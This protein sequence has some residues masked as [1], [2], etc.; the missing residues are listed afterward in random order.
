MKDSFIEIYKRLSE[1]KEQGIEAVLATV[2]EKEGSTPAVP[3]AKLLITTD[4]MKSGTVGG[5]ALE[6]AV[7]KDAQ[8]VMHDGKSML[9]KYNLSDDGKIVDAEATGMI[10]GGKVAIFFEYIAPANRIY[11]FGAGHVGK[12]ILY[13]LKNSD[14]HITVIDNRPEIA[15]K[16]IGANNFVISPYEEVFADETT[17]SDSPKTLGNVPEGGFF[18]ITTHTHELD[19]VVLKGI[20]ESNWKPA[21]IGMLASKRKV[22]TILKKLHEELDEKPDLSILYTPV[23]LD[24]GGNSPDEIAISIISQ[25]QAIRYGKTGQKHLK[26]EWN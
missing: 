9:K 25:I 22:E 7:I 12:A 23:G 13:H 4:G 1:L 5:G 2:V 6:M 11:I 10:C 15:E 17:V 20:Y 19:Y 14:F 3:G 16:I 21:Y 24:I 18:L 8:T 26:K